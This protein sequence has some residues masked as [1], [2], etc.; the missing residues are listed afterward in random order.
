MKSG[1]FA[2]IHNPD[3]PSFREYAVYFHDELEMRNRFGG[4]IIDPHTGQP[5]G[6]TAISYRSEPMVNRAHMIPDK[7]RGF[8][9]CNPCDER[10]SGG[11]VD[12]VKADHTLVDG[13]DVSMS[14]W[15]NGDPATFI[16]RAYVGD[17]A[18]FRL[19]HGGVK[20][21]H[22][23]HLHTHQW[24]LEADDPDSTIIDSISISPQETYDIDI[25]HGAGSLPG[26]IGDHIGTV[27]YIHI[28]MRACGPCGEYSID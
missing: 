8:K 11:V 7:D 10:D 1:A 24:K 20:E 15:T 25:L 23:F 26:S 4:Q 9:Y 21:T 27:I 13:E 14:S 6:V 2:D 22:V 3:K 16:P 19:I 18:R 28:S 17:P 12:I 5:M